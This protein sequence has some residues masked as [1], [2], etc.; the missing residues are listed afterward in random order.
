MATSTSIGLPEDLLELRTERC[1]R[2]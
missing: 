2:H 1:V